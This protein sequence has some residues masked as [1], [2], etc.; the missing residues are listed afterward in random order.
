MNNTNG[1]V[2]FND[3]IFLALDHGFNS[4][5]NN[6]GP[7]VPFIFVNKE[8]G[9][10]DLQRFAVNNVEDGVLEARN[11]INSIIN[12]NIMYAFAYDGFVTTNGKKFDAIVVE[13]KDNNS[14]K[15]IVLAQRYILKGLL[16]KKNVKIG[17]PVLLK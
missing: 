17:N 16:K 6:S 10:R 14:G 2:K 15:Q 7:L 1:E 12:N 8:D 3:L 5:E 4:I 9:T 11:Y 13:G